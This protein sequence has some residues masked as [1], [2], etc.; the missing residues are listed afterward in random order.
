MPGLAR[1]A[2]VLAVAGCH[3]SAA[4]PAG[5]I[6]STLTAKAL[7]EHAFDPQSLKGKP[8]IVMF[9]SPVCPHCLKEMPIAAKVGH[10]AGANVVAIFVVGKPS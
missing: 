10:D 7:G 8:S 3:G 5:D 6:A 2:V 9:V 4:V 1:L